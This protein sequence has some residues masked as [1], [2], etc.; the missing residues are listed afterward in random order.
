MASLGLP[1]PT[2]PFSESRE[3]SRGRRSHPA[4][5]WVDSG[6]SSPMVG[7]L[8]PLEDL[9]PPP[10]PLHRERLEVEDRSSPFPGP[11]TRPQSSSS[12][13]IQ[14]V[15]V[16]KEKEKIERENRRLK[17]RLAKMEKQLENVRSELD[18]VKEL[19]IKWGAGRGEVE[20]TCVRARVYPVEES[21]ADSEEEKQEETEPIDVE[22]GDTTIVL[23]EP[24][25]VGESEGETTSDRAS[26]DID[27]REAMSDDASFGVRL[28]TPTPLP[29]PISVAIPS[30]SAQPQPPSSVSDPSPSPSSSVQVQP[31]IEPK[32][33]L[34]SVAQLFVGSGKAK[35]TKVKPVK[36][37]KPTPTSDTNLKAKDAIAPKSG[38]AKTVLGW[39]TWKRKEKA[40]RPVA[41]VFEEGA[42]SE[43]IKEETTL[44]ESRV[45]ERRQRSA[46]VASSILSSGQ[47]A[48]EQEADTESL[49]ISVTSGQRAISIHSKD[50]PLVE[51]AGSASRHHQ[52][53]SAMERM[54]W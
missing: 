19:A 11:T 30:S 22:E 40:R 44:T 9:A 36:S 18:A 51:N 8:N 26:L 54:N 47:A 5:L 1:S 2:I 12:I 14:G 37:A 21:E 52:V 43:A 50:E 48:E 35:T 4:S 49:A 23:K 7:R 13:A 16:D 29:L 34:S 28:V 6:P 38:W 46:S 24:P 33:T 3:S 15:V 20:R 45:E 39:E 53:A 41:E 32:G 31:S 10:L 17:R 25:K 42:G 27:L